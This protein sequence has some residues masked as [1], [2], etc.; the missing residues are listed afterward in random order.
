MPCAPIFGQLQ[1]TPCH[2]FFYAVYVRTCVCVGPIDGL[3]CCCNER[4]CVKVSVRVCACACACACARAHAR[5][6]TSRTTTIITSFSSLSS[7]DRAHYDASASST[8]A[9]TRSGSSASSKT[10]SSPTT[11]ASP[12]TTTTKPSASPTTTSSPATIRE[13]FY[14]DSRDKVF[15]HGALVECCLL[16]RVMPGCTA[17]AALPRCRRCRRQDSRA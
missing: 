15:H 3:V 14:D 9:A 13:H 4:V 2:D 10:M 16:G 11:A 8:S 12:P 1:T 7:A 6:S 5:A 17:S